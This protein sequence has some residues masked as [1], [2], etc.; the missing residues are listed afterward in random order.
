MSCSEGLH[1]RLSLKKPKILTP[2]L[3]NPLD[4]IVPMTN[5]IPSPAAS[6]MS[7]MSNPNKFIKIISGRDRSR[8]AK[9]LK[10]SAGQPGSGSPWSLFEDQF[11]TITWCICGAAFNFVVDDNLTKVFYGSYH[12]CWWSLCNADDFIMF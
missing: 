2:S 4:N 1:G 11:L 12:S 5:S 9:A 8:K 7:N 6:Q 3:E 10:I